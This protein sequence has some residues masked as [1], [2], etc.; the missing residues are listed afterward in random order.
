MLIRCTTRNATSQ[1]V[2]SCYCWIDS[3]IFLCWL[4][5]I[6]LL[7]HS[8]SRNFLRVEAGG[9]SRFCSRFEW[10]ILRVECITCAGFSQVFYNRNFHSIVTSNDAAHFMHLNLCVSIGNTLNHL[11]NSIKLL[12]FVICEHLF[13]RYN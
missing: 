7:I 13:L 9:F 4:F 1:C 5:L 6:R 12:K 3:F 10:I 11:R 8:T 2:S